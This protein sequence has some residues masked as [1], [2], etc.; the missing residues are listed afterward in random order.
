MDETDS[1]L[2]VDSLKI[3]AK[4]IKS[5]KEKNPEMTI[6]I[7]THYKRILEYLTPDKLSIVIKGRITARKIDRTAIVINISAKVNPFFVIF[8]LSLR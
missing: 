6:L 5:L 3:I 8:Y 7:I 2:D 4:G 1:G